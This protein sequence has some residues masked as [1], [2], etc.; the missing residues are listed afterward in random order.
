[1]SWDEY[2]SWFRRRRKRFPSF[3]DWYFGDIEEMM[4]DMDR[5][6]EEMFREITERV[7]KGL[8]RE[9]K[10]PNGSTF[11]QMG[12]FVWGW[13]VTMGPGKK[14]VTR[15]FGN[16]KPSYGARPWEPPFALREKREPLVDVVGGDREI[17]VI[18]E[19]PGVD[20]QDI[21]INATERTLNISVDTEERKYHKE[22]KLPDEVDPASTR[23]SY[24]TGVFRDHAEKGQREEPDGCTDKNLVTRSV[25]FSLCPLVIVFSLSFFGPRF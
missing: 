6:V 19:L 1:M 25:F 23:A 3:D 17:T 16:L 14:P 12:P 13:S 4:R 15:E 22:L 11:R 10:L 18:A 2:P 20:K 5:M 9:R 7:P 21:N 24:K 8:V